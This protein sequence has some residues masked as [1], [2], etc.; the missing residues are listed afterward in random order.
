MIVV[1]TGDNVDFE[2]PLDLAVASKTI[3]N[4]LEDMSPG[5]TTGEVPPPDDVV[6]LPNVRGC[7][8]ER[9]IEYWKTRVPERPIDDFA[10]PLSPDERWR[11]LC[12]ADFLNLTPLLSELTTFIASEIKKCKTVEEMRAVMGVTNDFTPEEEAEIRKECGWALQ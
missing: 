11:L 4:L 8:M 5:A 12:A 7:D 9:I 3:A 6:P 1:K 10:A 2:V